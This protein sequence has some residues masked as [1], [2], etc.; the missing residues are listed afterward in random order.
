MEKPSAP[1]IYPTTRGEP[2]LN[3]LKRAMEAV[4]DAQLVFCVLP[5]KNADLYGGM[6][7]IVESNYIFD[8]KISNATPKQ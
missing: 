2:A 5:D 3:V 8:F 7:L 6:K 4:P 1:P